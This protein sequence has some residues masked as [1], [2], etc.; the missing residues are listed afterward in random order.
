[1]WCGVVKWLVS[2][3]LDSG[4]SLPFLA[5][6][7]LSRCD[8]CRNFEVFGRSLEDF[9]EIPG[10]LRTGD[11][12]QH[13]IISGLESEP[14]EVCRNI[15]KPLPMNK[16]KPALIGASFAFL[17]LLGTIWITTP[18]HGPSTILGGFKDVDL[19]PLKEMISDVESP[20]E[21]EISELRQ[22]LETVGS[23][24]KAFFDSFN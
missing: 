5:V 9:S 18:F 2:R 22:G 17:L 20:Y 21:E 11:N 23:N 6:K 8:A 1:M 24:I 10:Q 12:L 19:A 3:S 14:G 13:K 7:H 4:R 15:K 16:W